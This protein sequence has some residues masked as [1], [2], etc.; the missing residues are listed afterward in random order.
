MA[1]STIKSVIV[2]L[3]IFSTK[4]QIGVLLLHS[5]NFSSAKYGVS[6]RYHLVFYVI[7]STTSIFFLYNIEKL[8]SKLVQEREMTKDNGASCE[9]RMKSDNKFIYAQRLQV[10]SLTSKV[11]KT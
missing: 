9:A 4:P 7:N 3:L 2:L 11:L 1:A 5:I 8:N 10:V 6:Y